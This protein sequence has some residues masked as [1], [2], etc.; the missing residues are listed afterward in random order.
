MIVEQSR[1]PITTKS[2]HGVA[3]ISQRRLSHPARAG[4][5]WAGY[6]KIF[7]RV[8]FLLKTDSGYPKDTG[9]T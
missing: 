4:F 5:F 3:R 9:V 7:L 1:T 8:E 2:A 6:Q